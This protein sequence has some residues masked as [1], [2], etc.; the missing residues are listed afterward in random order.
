MYEPKAKTNS[1]KA[2]SRASVNIK[3]NYYTVEYSEERVIP[4]LPDIDI[5]QEKSYLW[6]AVNKQCDDQIEEIVKSFK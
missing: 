4:E 5:E 6:D 2:T 3:N 1:I